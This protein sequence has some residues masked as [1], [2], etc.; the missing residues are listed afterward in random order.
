MVNVTRISG[1]IVINRP[2]DAVFD[3]V[4]DERNEALYNPELL[5]SDKLTDGPVGEGTRFYA[6]HTSPRFH[7][8]HHAPHLSTSLKSL[9][10]P[11]VM[12]V[13]ITAFDRPYRMASK[14][15]MSWSEVEGE[16]A[17]EPV[18][19]AT[20]V[21]WT[22]DVHPRSLA[23]LSTPVLGLFGRRSER[24]CWRSLK[25]RLESTAASEP[26]RSGIGP[27]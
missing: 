24:A 19:A 12:V 14:T 6:T 22:W 7:A 25:R 16:L 4:A 18:G 27:S 21:R 5:H 1:E 2:I 23:N 10:R 20:R 15:T 3:F 13:D 9:R 8:I 26:T 17:F 11:V